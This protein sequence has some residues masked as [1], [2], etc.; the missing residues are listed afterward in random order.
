MD[1]EKNVFI[2]IKEAALMQLILSTLE[3]FAVRHLE[4]RTHNK[5][6]ETYGLLWGS[7][8]KIS[9]NNTQNFIYTISHITID[10]SA[11]KSKN[12]VE[13]NDEALILKKDIIT[14]YWPYYKFLGD[15]HTHP[16]KRKKDFDYQDVERERLFEF[17]KEDF[18][19]VENSAEYW[20]ELNYRVG[21]VVTIIDMERATKKVEQIKDNLLV[22][23]LGNYRIWIKGYWVS[24]K[25]HNKIKARLIDDIYISCPH[26]TGMHEFTQFGRFRYGRHEEGEIG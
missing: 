21:I 3:A 16:Y 22:F 4:K 7:F 19:F 6:L 20:Y 26:L 12:Y 18:D 10:T 9:G 24:Y 1:V 5:Y 15:F 8:T 11:K 25:K 17:S 13:P 2:V 23:N 14:S